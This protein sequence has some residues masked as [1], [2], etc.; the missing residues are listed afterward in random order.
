MP[1]PRKCHARVGIQ[2]AQ[3][4]WSPVHRFGLG[5]PAP[6]LRT[7][8]PGC[9]EGS[10]RPMPTLHPF[11][12]EVGIEPKGEVRVL[13]TRSPV[14]PHN[15]VHPVSPP[16]TRPTVGLPSLVSPVPA[17]R[18]SPGLQRWSPVRGLRRGSPVRHLR[19]GSRVRGLQRRSPV[20]G[21]QQGT[22]SEA[23]SDTD[24]SPATLIMEQ[25]M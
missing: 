11:R 3:R 18:A 8:S 10:V 1:A 17:P 21:R 22:Q 25:L 14:L 20:W 5:Y 16:R 13:S 6:A 23:S 12:A 19:R 7:V 2:P 4:V 24:S 9:W 15:P